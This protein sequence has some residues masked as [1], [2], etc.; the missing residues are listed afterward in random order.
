MDLQTRFL[1]SYDLH[2]GLTFA[3]P[4]Q[5]QRT[6]KECKEFSWIVDHDVSLDSLLSNHTKFLF[7]IP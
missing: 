5:R 3:I 7:F 2:A 4:T 6:H 1:H